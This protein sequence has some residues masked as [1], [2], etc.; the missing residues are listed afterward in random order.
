[1]CCTTDRA[2]GRGE[3]RRWGALGLRVLADRPEGGRG[4]IRT[5]EGRKGKGEIRA[6][7]GR[8]LADCGEENRWGNVCV[9]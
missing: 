4:L 9:A 8:S 7:R 2:S 3:E 1:V 5:G 6:K